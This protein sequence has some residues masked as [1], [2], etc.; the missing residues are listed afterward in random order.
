M[1]SCIADIL[2]DSSTCKRSEILKSRRVGSRSSH[3]ASI[4]HCT[5]LTESLYERCYSRTLLTYSHIDT[6]DRLACLIVG[7]L[8]DDGVDSDGSLTCLTVTDDKLALSTSDRDHCI[9]SLQTGLERLLYRLTEH[10]TRSLALKWHLVLG[11]FDRT[12]TVERLTKRVDNATEHLLIDLNRGDALGT[13]YYHTFANLFSTTEKHSTHVVL[14]EV[15]DNGH[16]T[17]LEFQQFVSLCIAQT[18][19][20]SHA[21]AD[22]E[23]RAHLVELC[24]CIY[25]LELFKEHLAN[26]AGFDITHIDFLQFDNLQ[27][28]NSLILPF[29]NLQSDKD[30]IGSQAIV[31]S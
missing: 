17:I 9:D 6:I 13:F 28:D 7:L 5:L 27:F 23:H 16:D 24:A 15:H 3:D 11:A 8:V 21:I 14:F 2:S 29:D 19:D 4:R 1:T 22:S 18:I 12:H 25:A 26:F 31:K 20:T 10:N 30:L